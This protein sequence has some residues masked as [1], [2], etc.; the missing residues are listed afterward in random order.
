MAAIVDV[1]DESDGNV[2]GEVEYW[3]QETEED[4]T[5]QLVIVAVSH[6]PVLLPSN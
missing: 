5:E 4:A 2:E 1:F 6:K 3:I